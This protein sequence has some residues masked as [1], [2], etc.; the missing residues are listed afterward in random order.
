MPVSA[1]STVSE[2]GK[3]TTTITSAKLDE[4]IK[5]APQIASKLGVKENG[6]FAEVTVNNPANTKTFTV[7]LPKVAQD[8][9]AKEKVVEF[10]INS[11]SIDI[12]FDKAAIST[13]QKTTGMDAQINA[14]PVTTTALSNEAQKAIG[15]RP[16]YDLTLVYGSKNLTSFGNGKVYV[17]IPYTLG[18]N[19][20]AGNVGV[21]YV[22]KNGKLSYIKDSSY[23]MTRKMV[24]FSTNHFSTYGVVYNRNAP[25]FN[26]IVNHWAED[27][28][29]FVTNRGLLNGTENGQ[30]S[31]NM[32]IT[33]RT[34]VTALGRLANVNIA[35]Y[36]KSS[37]TDVKADDPCMG[38]AEWAAKNN[39]MKGI[40]NGQFAPDSSITREEVADI[41]YNYAKVTN[42][43]LPIIR[44][45]VFFADNSNISVSY[46][47][48][49]KAMQQAGILMGGDNN[50]LNPKAKAT[51]A[52]VS[53]MLHRY[54]NL[55]IDRATAEGWAKNDSGR[56]LYYNNGKALI[57]WQT[58]SGTK[59]NFNANGILQIS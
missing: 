23:D 22:D 16:V 50:K 49:V 18:R 36:T 34:L 52:E 2:T 1:D 56:W 40:G 59:Y 44:K 3:A 48:S 58:I 53:A 37:F 46:K 17:G 55:T 6:I 41:L 42:Y 25:I 39:I 29:L 19:E 21:V 38:Y 9:L 24:I 8:R 28:V 31:P 26:D 12:G 15:N 7:N 13:I 32:S 47:S 54:I 4:I 20:Q 51:R 43:T 33:R 10:R 27:E 35:S 45:A 30:F 14:N 5:K 11:N 57:G